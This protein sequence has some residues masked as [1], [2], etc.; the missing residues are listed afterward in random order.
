MALKAI[1]ENLDGLSEE[2][3]KEYKQRDD[4]KYIL[5]V[6]SVDG[7][8]LAEVS[9][10]QSALSKEREN[11]RKANEKLKSFD[12][13]DPA[14]ARE[15]IKKVEE[16]ATWE[17]EQ[18]VKEQIEAVKSQMMDAH[19]KEKAKLQERLDKLS[20]SLEEAMIIS[21]ASQELAKEKGSVRLLMPHIRQQTRL[22]EADGK[23]VVEVMGSDG[24]PRLTGSDGHP[25]SISELIAEM[26][27]QND[28]A[29]AFEGTGAT[30]TGA[31]GTTG[32]TKTNTTIE[33]LSK[34][35]PG[36]RLK[37]AREMGINK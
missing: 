31:T 37:R 29:S 4:G 28:F 30:G 20:K 14:K 11:S 9:K 27:T 33:E 18:K 5:D 16:M 15:A 26:K 25:M 3:R 34:L 10:L 8:E 35:P 1:L 21:V 23:F 6:M 13:L 32:K 19:G 24:N 7:L 17:P 36:E 2:I 22:R 12:D